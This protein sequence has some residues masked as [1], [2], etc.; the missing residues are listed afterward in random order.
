MK[1]KPLQVS[2]VSPVV[3]LFVCNKLVVNTR[4]RIRIRFLCLIFTQGTRFWQQ[5]SNIFYIQKFDPGQFAKRGPKKC[6]A[7]LR[8]QGG[9][10]LARHM[11]LP[12]E[13]APIATMAALL[14][15]TKSM[16][17]VYGH[18]TLKTPVL[19]RSPKLS[20]VESGQYLDG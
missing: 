5:N 14:I 7:R 11:Y 12:I 2:G 3:F 18:I 10:I 8:S 1:T 9:G 13:S 15:E 6:S 20:N 16:L 4:R 19:V 17:N